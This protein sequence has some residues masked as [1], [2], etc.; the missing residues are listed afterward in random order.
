MDKPSDKQLNRI[1]PT[2]A[3]AEALERISPRRTLALVQ[4]D[5]VVA[6]EPLPKLTPGSGPREQ[7]WRYRVCVQGQPRTS[8]YFTSF[9]PA[10]GYAEELAQTRNARI[11]FLE[12][13]VPSMLADYRRV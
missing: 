2:E 11:M 9:A 1:S 6:R 13:Q 4:G 10:A 12:D 8:Q 3:P 5:I 7:Q